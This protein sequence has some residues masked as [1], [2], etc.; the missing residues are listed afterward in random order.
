MCGHLGLLWNCRE[1]CLDVGSSGTGREEN[2]RRVVSKHDFA[3][4]ERLVLRGKLG[5]AKARGPVHKVPN[6]EHPRPRE[7]LMKLLE[8]NAMSG[9][10][11]EQRAPHSLLRCGQIVFDEIHIC[12][13][14]MCF[15]VELSWRDRVGFEREAKVSVALRCRVIF[16][17]V[18]CVA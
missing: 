6:G 10:E 7:S 13:A 18:W 14:Q 3:V 11:H 9:E 15:V 5:E 12:K 4:Q 8:W 17:G 16:H 2:A 1:I